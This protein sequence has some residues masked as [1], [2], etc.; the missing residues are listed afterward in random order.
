MPRPPPHPTLPPRS[1]IQDYKLSLSLVENIGLVLENIGLQI[2]VPLCLSVDGQTP[3]T[4][5]YKSFVALSFDHENWSSFY[6]TEILEQSRKSIK[7]IGRVTE[8]LIKVV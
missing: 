1:Y 3:G 6:F 4:A 8:T 7:L 2:S 5:W